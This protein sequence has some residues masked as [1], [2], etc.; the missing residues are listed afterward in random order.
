MAGAFAPNVAPL[1]EGWTLHYDPAIA[2]PFRAM[3]S[4]DP[5]AAQQAA[6]DGEAMLWQMYDA[7][8]AR[9]L[10]LRGADSDLLSPATAQA[11]TGRGPKA[12]CVEFGGVGHAPRL[13]PPTR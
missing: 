5:K 1:Q 12:C 4:A 10:L 7:I 2:V 8:T 13:W 3:L 11:M 6:R 9:T